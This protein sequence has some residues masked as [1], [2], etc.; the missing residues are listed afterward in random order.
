MVFRLICS[1]QAVE[2]KGVDVSSAKIRCE[3]KF[4]YSI[5]ERFEQGD[6]TS[7]GLDGQTMI[8]GIFCVTEGR[9]GG[10][11]VSNRKSLFVCFIVFLEL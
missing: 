7:I 1:I 10:A 2:G 6:F 11:G 9:I 4:S 5:P 8:R 3:L